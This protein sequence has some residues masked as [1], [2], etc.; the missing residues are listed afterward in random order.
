MQRGRLSRVKLEPGTQVRAMYDRDGKFYDGIIAKYFGA[1]SM[2]Q[3]DW[4]GENGA[5]S[6][7]KPENV[8]VEV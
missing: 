5:Y 6:F 3:V 4:E 8:S 2:Y 7:V 1:S